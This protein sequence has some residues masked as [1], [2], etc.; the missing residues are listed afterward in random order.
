MRHRRNVEVR[1]LTFAPPTRIQL[2]SELQKVGGELPSRTLTPALV[3]SYGYLAL[4]D[5][6]RFCGFDWPEAA[7]MLG[8]YVRG[9][10]PGTVATSSEPMEFFVGV[11]GSVGNGIAG[12]V[13]F[14]VRTA[15]GVRLIDLG[16]LPEVTVD[17]NGRVTN[18]SDWYIPNCVYV[19]VEQ[20]DEEGVNWADVGINWG[21][22]DG[23]DLT[24]D[25]RWERSW[26]DILGGAAWTCTWCTSRGST[27]VST[28]SSA[29]P[30]TP[31]T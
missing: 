13:R 21:A 3:T 22:D 31:S 7:G 26:S 4:T 8:G 19:S 1:E 14:V 2:C 5:A 25:H 20:G 6:G 10:A 29:R 30:R 28:C 24:T 11:P 27:P 23:L 16:E 15:R 9:P 18:A 12:A 17:A